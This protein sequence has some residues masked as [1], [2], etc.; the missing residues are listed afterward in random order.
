[1]KD[2]CLFL[3]Q[4]IRN[5]GLQSGL[6]EE[7]A[8]GVTYCFGIILFTYKMCMQSY[9]LKAVRIQQQEAVSLLLALSAIPAYTHLKSPFL[10]VLQGCLQQFFA[11]HVLSF[12]FPCSIFQ[13]F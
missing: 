9:F 13:S 7:T 12:L 10:A 3:T 1:M 8:D 6:R 2:R 4:L 11:L 5:P